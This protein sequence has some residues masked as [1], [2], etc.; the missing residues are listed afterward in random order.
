MSV[1]GSLNENLIC[2]NQAQNLQSD[3]DALDALVL[4]SE[5]SMDESNMS[6]VKQVSDPED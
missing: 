6:V 1:N 3:R 5:L 2:D 4:I